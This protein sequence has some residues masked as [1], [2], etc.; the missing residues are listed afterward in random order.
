MEEQ[1]MVGGALMV[2]PVTE[3]HGSTVQLYLPG[4]N[5]VSNFLQSLH[6]DPVFPYP[7]PGLV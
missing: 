7:T 4:A 3:Q 6:I 2:R 5:T 1:M